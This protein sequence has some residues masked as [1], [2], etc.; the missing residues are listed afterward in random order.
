MKTSAKLGILIAG[1][2]A[3]PSFAAIAKRSDVY[4]LT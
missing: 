4:L 3:S 2:A 1:L